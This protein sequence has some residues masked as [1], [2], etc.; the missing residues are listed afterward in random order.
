MN[1]YRFFPFTVG[2]I[3]CLTAIGSMT[4]QKHFLG[5]GVARA[6]EAETLSNSNERQVGEL[7]LIAEL[8][9]TPGNVTVSRDGRIFASVHGMRRGSAQLIEIFS[10]SNSWQPF[11]N[12]SW[13]GSPGSSPDVLNTAHGV[14]IDSQNRLWVI[15]HGNW[16]PDEQPVAQPKLVAFDIALPISMQTKF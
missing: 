11:P 13:N 15:D 10:D 1:K 14:T 6:S 3:V 9:I 4:L 16:M 12:E 7:E 5:Q 2:A 8:D